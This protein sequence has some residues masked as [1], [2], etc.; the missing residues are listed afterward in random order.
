MIR[1][2]R[3]IFPAIV[4]EEVLIHS[5]VE[6]GLFSSGRYGYAGAEWVTPTGLKFHLVRDMNRDQLLG[7]QTYGRST[8]VPR[9][10]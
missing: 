3:K 10:R 7:L 4:S 5:T 9:L 2:S 1:V 6:K 8:G